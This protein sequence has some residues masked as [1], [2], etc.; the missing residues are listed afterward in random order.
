MNED[1]E[2][3]FPRVPDEVRNER[4]RVAVRVCAELRRAGLPTSLANDN[5]KLAEGGALVE[6]FDDEGP[7]MFVSWRVSEELEWSWLGPGERD[8][9]NINLESTARRLSELHESGDVPPMMRHSAQV[10]EL[11]M[12]TV[13]GI[14]VS[15]GLHAHPAND[16]YSPYAVQV[17]CA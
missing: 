11:M 14:L 2:R 12:N 16:S 6:V 5:D 8:G 4:R 7:D 10:K 17:T 15:A 3:R 13:I 9:E 1:Y